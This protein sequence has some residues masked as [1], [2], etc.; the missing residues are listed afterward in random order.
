[1]KIAVLGGAGAMGGIFGGW[2]ARAGE[3]VTLVDVSTA[4]VAKINADGLLIEEKDGS[5][6]RVKLAA[7]TEPGSVGV[8]DLILNFVK[9][10]HTQAAM[11]AARP[12]IGAADNRLSA[13]ATA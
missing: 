8:A 5:A 6:T 11:E 4:A 3:N 9:C 1:M 12:M 7:T 13:K 10:Y 2:L